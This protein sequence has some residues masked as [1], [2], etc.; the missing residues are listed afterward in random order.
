[1]CLGCTYG[2]QARCDDYF[3]SLN[4][5]T[6][7]IHPVLTLEL[8]NCQVAIRGARRKHIRLLEKATSYM[9]EG[10]HFAPSFR[11][12]YWD[13]REHLM[14]YSAKRGYVAPIGLTDDIITTL[15]AEGIEYEIDDQR[16]IHGRRR[17]MEWNPDVVP[18]DYQEGANRAILKDTIGEPL[19]GSGLLKMPIR[20]GKTKTAA[21]YIHALGLR[22]VVIV[23]S[24]MLLYQTVESLQECL[25]GE[26]IGC[27]GDGKCDIQFITVITI[28]TL[29]AWRNKTKPKLK[30]D[31]A[32]GEMVPVVVKNDKG[33][34]VPKKVSDRDPR[35]AIITD[36]TDVCVI[37]E[38]HHL[39][40]DSEWHVIIGEIDARFKC[41]LSAT[42]YLESEVE[43]GRGIIW[44]KGCVGPMRIDIS[45]SELIK[46]GFL[47][48]QTVRMFRVTE[49]AKIADWKW[50][51]MLQ[52][53]GIWDNKARN[54]MIVDSAKKLADKGMKVMIV[55]RRLNHIANLDEMMWGA[56]LPHEVVTGKDNRHVRKE[57]VDDFIHGTVS[58]I[59]GTVFAEGVDIP[60]VE[61][62]IVAEGGKD[63]KNTM[64]RMRNMTIMD[65][66]N[67]A[68][69][70]DFWDD[71]NAYLLG[72]SKDRLKVYESVPEFDVEVV[73]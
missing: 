52:N 15:V 25:P 16:R 50:S 10:A 24:Q 69:L 48:A 18:R 51:Q 4:A 62:V 58:V 27:V 72:H 33:K 46:A 20:S 35:Y 12:G 1:M 44:L 49:P 9:V 60:E 37:D 61:V 55:A 30:K 3:Q 8:T 14:A 59:V 6:S 26:V 42:A 36:N 7:I 13:G 29:M 32:T 56:N 28:Q 67:R 45:E 17:A 68:L 73:G 31:K 5:R 11:K 57:K 21:T 38:A 54:R 2:I 40:G 71:T 66:K 39:R 22:S 70:I 65:G 47:M 43:Q 64:Q 19:F 23:P 34:L 53:E 41:A 63:A